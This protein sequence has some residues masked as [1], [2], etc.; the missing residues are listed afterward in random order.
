MYEISEQKNGKDNAASEDD[1]MSAWGTITDSLPPEKLKQINK[2]KLGDV[3]GL[4]RTIRSQFYRQTAGTRNNL[5][6]K[7]QNAKLEDFDD[8]E[9]YAASLELVISRLSGLGYDVEEEDKVY[10]LLKGL[11]VDYEAVKSTLRLPQQPPLSWDQHMH[12][13]REFIANSPSIV[14]HTTRG[15]HKDS[16]FHTREESKRSTYQAI[17]RDFT[18]GKCRRGN[19]CRYKH[20]K[21]PRKCAHCGK[22]NHME[23]DCWKKQKEDKQKAKDEDKA[24]PTAEETKAEDSDEFCCVIHEEV[25]ADVFAAGSRFKGSGHLLIDGAATCHICQHEDDC[26]DIQPC[27]IKVRVGGNTLLTCL[28]TGKRRVVTKDF[29]PFILVDVRIIPNFG[30]DVISEPKLLAAGCRIVKVGHQFKTKKDTLIIKNTLT[31][32]CTKI[33]TKA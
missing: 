19:R 28:K 12:T 9:A 10:Y 16:A 6:D 29:K 33:K 26:Y 30:T 18:R 5:K 4:L 22:T 27:N 8:F 3:E 11:P 2:V 31:L 7:L 14:G 24:N 13:L 15:K 1:R 25:S 20:V 21:P 23:K 32:T 17:C